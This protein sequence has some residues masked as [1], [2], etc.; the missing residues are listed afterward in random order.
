[1][2]PG[3]QPSQAV[4]T[5]RLESMVR[6]RIPPPPAPEPCPEP[7]RRILIKAMSPEPERRYQSAADLAAELLAFGYGGKVRATEE[8]PEAT[9]RTTRPNPAGEGTRRTVPPPPP[10]PAP[11]I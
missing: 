8:D 6:S 9:R 4:S 1:M 10:P 5:E 7:L 3:L 2:A 11:Q